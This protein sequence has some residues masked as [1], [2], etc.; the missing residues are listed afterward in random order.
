MDSWIDYIGYANGK[1]DLSLSRSGIQFD[2]GFG[3]NDPRNGFRHNGIA[4]VVF[5]DGHVKA[6]DEGRMLDRAG[7]DR[8]ESFSPPWNAKWY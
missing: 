6:L 5:C 3:K 2:L 1:P 7:K 8:S 4:N